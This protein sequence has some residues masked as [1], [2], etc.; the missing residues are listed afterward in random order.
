M[1]RVATIDVVRGLVMII[2]ALDHVRDLL[3]T[4]ALTQN[5][6]DLATTTAPLFFT[7]WITHLC[8][9]T[10]VFLAGTS[11]YLSLRKKG[12]SSQQRAFLLKRGLVLIGLELTLINFAFWTDIHFRSLMLQVIFVIGGGLVLLSVLVRFQVRTLLIVGLVIVCGHDLLLLVPPFAGQGARLV[13]SVLFRTDVFPLGPNFMLLAGYP[14]IPWFGIMLLGY[15]CGPLFEQPIQVGRRRL[16]Q[17]G[18]GTLAV[19]GLLRLV[20]SYGD[21]A[22]WQVQPG[23]LFTVLSFLNVS[24]YPPS[25]L[26]AALML[27]IMLV[28]LGLFDGKNNVLTRF[29][30]VYGQ[31]P[32]FY[33]LIHWYLVKA[34]M[35]GML[36]MQGYALRDMP[37]GPLNFGRPAGAGVSLPVVYAV[38][39]ALVILLYPLCR[40]YGRYKTSHPEVA[41]TRYL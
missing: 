23:T 41:W 24:K 4:P 12:D 38:W 34:A 36:L 20:N 8:A 14:L 25:L 19:F 37:I 35:I 15:G 3:H 29:L 33:Y 26:Y 17:L 9:P 10:F 31:V 7:R 1:K 28:L 22:P 5:P 11:V 6:T 40:W 30:T 2:M 18:V 16:W 21:A 13:W 39:L 32:L 27:G